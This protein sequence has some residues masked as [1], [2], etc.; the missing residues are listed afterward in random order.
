MRKIKSKL[1]EVYVEGDHSVTEQQSLTFL[2]CVLIKYFACWSS[3]EL[4][5]LDEETEKYVILYYVVPILCYLHVKQ[6]TQWLTDKIYLNILR[7]I[8]LWPG[9]ICL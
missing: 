4:S 1:Y 8:F 2:V 7:H 6:W 3:T 9:L 5:I